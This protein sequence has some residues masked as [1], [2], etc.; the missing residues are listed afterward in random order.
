MFV[1]KTTMLSLC[2][3]QC[4]HPSLTNLVLYLYGLYLNQVVFAYRFQI[5][6]HM[7]HRI[8]MIHIDALSFFVIAS[9]CITSTHSH[10]VNEWWNVFGLVVGTS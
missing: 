5:A 3:F 8:F 2:L 9:V 7:P 6:S 1:P 10:M 4:C